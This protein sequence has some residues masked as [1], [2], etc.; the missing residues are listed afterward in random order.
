MFHVV[1]FFSSLYRFTPVELVFLAE[2]AK[3]ISPAAKAFDVLQGETSVQMG[4]L[5]PP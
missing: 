2:Y 4:W 1:F 3:T 5:V